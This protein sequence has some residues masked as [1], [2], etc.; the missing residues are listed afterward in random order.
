MFE[1]YGLFRIVQCRFLRTIFFINS[2]FKIDKSI[3]YRIYRLIFI[4]V[5]SILIFSMYSLSIKFVIQ[6]YLLVFVFIYSPSIDNLNGISLHVYFT[7]HVQV[8]GISNIRW[9][10]CSINQMLSIR[11][12]WIS[13]IFAKWPQ[14][15]DIAPQFY[16][17]CY[18]S[19]C[20][21][22]CG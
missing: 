17:P 15:H 16:L 18:S 22:K 21:T 2:T 12:R 10:Q 14:R 11:A 19:F 13:S 6:Y 1:M 4:L 8:R 20:L 9:P 3:S 5:P 7:L